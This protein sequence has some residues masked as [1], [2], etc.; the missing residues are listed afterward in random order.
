MVSFTWLQSIL[1]NVLV[2]V[3][4][5]PI[6]VV[7]A[8]FL[9]GYLLFGVYQKY[10]VD[11]W[12][13]GLG[14]MFFASVGASLLAAHLNFAFLNRALL[15]FGAAAFV[16]SFYLLPTDLYLTPTMM[17]VALLLLSSAVA[18]VGFAP[19]NGKY[20]QFH[21]NYWFSLVVAVLGGLLIA[22]LAALLIKTFGFL[23][24]V[25][26]KAAVY[27]YS[28]IVSLFLIGL[29]I[30]LSL[31]PTI[32]DEQVK[33]GEPDEFT[34][35]VTALFVKYVFVPFFLLFALLFHGFAI[36]VLL[37]GGMPSGQIAPYGIV[38]VAMGIATYFMAFPTAAV[39][40]PLVRFFVRYWMWLLIV[41]LLLMIY[42]FFARLSQYGLTPSRFFLAA[43]I[44]WA[45][46]LVGY[47]LVQKWRAGEFDLRVI[48]FFA[49]LILGLASVGPW[50]AEAVS[51]NWQMT[52]LVDQ[53]KAHEVL[54]EGRIAKKLPREGVNY[55]SKVNINSA[56]SYFSQNNRGERLAFL[57][58]D[59]ARQDVNK[60]RQDGQFY[61][62]RRNRVLLAVKDQLGLGTAA[63]KAR[64]QGRAFTYRVSGAL[65]LVVPEKGTL[66]G[67]LYYQFAEGVDD[68][69]AKA[70][71]TT[72]V[73]GE[74][75]SSVFGPS[76]RRSISHYVKGADFWFVQ[77]GA[78]VG[79]FPLAALRAIGARHQGLVKRDA[80]QSG[81]KAK[82]RQGMSVVKVPGK[83][84]NNG[85]SL[86]MLVTSLSYQTGE[87]EGEPIALTGVGYWL[88]V[89]N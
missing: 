41:P 81:L 3:R 53:L 70:E 58:D 42:A 7:L 86:E 54:A 68:S 15:G 64:R 30:W 59:A 36:K 44:L 69:A 34:A 17:P 11:Y 40:G 35:K 71:S 5:F 19:S 21:H 20:W 50:G 55:R 12:A 67:P 80:Q 24:G 25:N 32:F 9:T 87:S 45:V 48:A 85:G 88:F 33:H 23:F 22:G 61:E 10:D 75:S 14:A 63:Q 78:V 51:N 77:K 46:I 62:G 74:R 27:Q 8:F 26:I 56:L 4:R 6:P 13:F 65:D 2:V 29:L 47:A 1:P 73:V 57:L 52:R 31:L 37:D 18:Y 49:A 89:G 82:E 83:M 43:F 28:L 72:E 84:R 60:E 79:S 39:G 76:G 16:G 66:I 38:L